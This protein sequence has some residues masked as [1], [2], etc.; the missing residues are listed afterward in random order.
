MSRD[1]V[2]LDSMLERF[3]AEAQALAKSS[4]FGTG[5]VDARTG[6]LLDANA[7]LSV[8]T[9]YSHR[10]LVGMPARELTHPDE[11][12][13]EWGRLDQTLRGETP[14]YTAEKRYLR[15]DGRTIWVRVGARLICDGDG[16]PDYLF[17]IMIDITAQKTLEAEREIIAGYAED[18]L[19]TLE[20][21]EKQKDEFLAMLAH[22]LRNPLA[23]IRNSLYILHHVDAPAARASALAVIDRQVSQLSHLV[24]DLL[25]ATRIATGQ[26]QLRRVPFE[27]GALVRRIVLD[28][29]SIFA[30]ASVALV[31]EIAVTPCV[32]LVDEVRIVQAL[33]NLLGNAAKYTPG[34][35]TTTVTVESAG[36]TATI[37][38]RDTGPGIP[39]E[40]APRL[41]EPFA[42]A[43]TTLDR[44]KGGLGLGLAIVKG[45]T[46]MHGGSVA[47]AEAP[48]GG[49]IFSIQLPTV[50]GGVA[51]PLVVG[52]TPVAPIRVL[53]IDDNTDS[54]S[55]VSSAL[56]RCN[57]RVEIANDGLQGLVKARQFAPDV[58]LC[59]IGLPGMTGYAVARAMRADPD[60]EHIALVAM[61]GYAATEDVA[62][63]RESGFDEHLAKPASIEEIEAVFARVLA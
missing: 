50:A 3:E 45:L 23:P 2:R 47:V 46:E 55:S 60:L 5:K 17:G 19:R 6:R 30:H 58:V 53:V 18:R 16:K 9:G 33:G 41:F 21:R 43:A 63:A 36:A 22:E 35:G 12:A 32:V 24:D 39:A 10:E 40:L 4:V 34:G 61:T 62:R 25:D 38:V 20:L 1:E 44:A 11:Q 48:G 28:Y 14:E 26:I 54:A 42:Q 57:H 8:I 7:Q 51:L 59:D 29:E 56:E 37:R 31:C 13:R 15:K 52:L 49:T 27:L